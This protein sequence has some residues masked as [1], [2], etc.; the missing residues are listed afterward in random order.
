MSYVLL[1]SRHS[2]LEC[3][4][5][6]KN[7]HRYG[8]FTWWMSRLFLLFG[9]KCIPTQKH[10]YINR[11]H[12]MQQ[13]LVHD[14][15]AILLHLILSNR[16]NLAYP[17]TKCSFYSNKIPL[18]KVKIS[19]ISEPNVDNDFNIWKLSS[20]TSKK[21]ADGAMCVWNWSFVG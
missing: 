18:A 3:V 20:Q 5:R 21:A 8:N 6:A 11:V 14:S 17:L 16:R 2:L 9:R 13:M 15:T 19:T 4:W 1:K 12:L 10:K 7:S